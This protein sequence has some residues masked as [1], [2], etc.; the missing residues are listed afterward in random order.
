M[1]RVSDDNYTVKGAGYF[2]MEMGSLFVE[3]MGLFGNL[4]MDDPV[5]DTRVLPRAPTRIQLGPSYWATSLVNPGHFLRGHYI[6]G[7]L[8]HVQSWR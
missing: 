4:T 5:F 8:K 2:T 3:V 1:T 6:N 7:Y